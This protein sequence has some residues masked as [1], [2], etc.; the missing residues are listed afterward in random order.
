VRQEIL[1]QRIR[2]AN[3]YGLL[4]LNQKDAKEY[5]PDQRDTFLIRIKGRNPTGI[6]TFDNL[7]HRDKFKMIL[8]LTFDDLDLPDDDPQCHLFS[9]FE[10][11]QIVKFFEAYEHNKSI[12][13]ESLLMIHCQGGIS[14]SAAVGCAYADYSK[15]PELEE[16]LRRC[17]Q[18]N[19]HVY[20]TLINYM[21]NNPRVEKLDNYYMN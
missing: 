3:K 2:I 1:N 20:R 15:N 4:V 11:A 5:R 14:R 18:P 10:A 12:D 21:Q 9:D 13:A 17:S 16:A 8:E 7:T 19:A 6:S